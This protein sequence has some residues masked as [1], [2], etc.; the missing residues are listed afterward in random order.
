MG[1]R[2]MYINKWDLYFDPRKDI[3]TSIIVWVKPPHLSLHYWNDEDLK[4]IGNSLGKYIEKYDPKPPMFF[5]A[6]I[7]VEVD[8]EKG[9]L[10]A[11]NLTMDGWNHIQTVDYE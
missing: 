2:G 5:C 1:P 9:L 11:I 10:E 8:M 3:P 6:W 4:A 7:Y